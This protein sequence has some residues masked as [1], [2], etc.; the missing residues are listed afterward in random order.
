MNAEENERVEVK[1][2]RGVYADDV[3]EA[4]REMRLVAAGTGC[5][6]YFYHASISPRE[7]EHLTPEQWDYAIDRLEQNLGLDG[8]ARF[9]VE[10]EKKGRTHR[11]I[12]WSRIDPD[13]MTATSDSF[14]YLVHNT[15]RE[16]LE[17]VFDHEPTPLPQ[18]RGT[19][20]R[21]WEHFRAQESGIDPKA[22]K[23]EVTALWQA[24]DSGA[25]FQAA[26]DNAGYVLCEG[27]RRDFVIVD[28]AGDVHSLARRIDGVKVTEIRQRMAGIDPER[29]MSVQ[30]ATQWVKQESE[31]SPPNPEGQV[32][33]RKPESYQEPAPPINPKLRILEKYAHD[34]PALAPPTTYPVATS[35]EHFAQ[36]SE[37]SLRSKEAESP[38]T[39]GS[40]VPESGKHAW[41]ILHART[42]DAPETGEDKTTELWQHLFDKPEERDKPHDEPERER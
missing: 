10:H 41:E 18:E 23:A 39:G 35:A 4:F 24:S 21:D 6:N 25:A 20:I 15:T 29:L 37:A 8:H 28:H 32:M 7:D 30:E 11:H 16:E 13:T 40:T 2:I 36:M 38:R 26:L 34:H 33:G 31:A 14:N 42:A 17:Q 1:E 27:D 19:R 3:K 5:Q 9:Q 12:V 22:V